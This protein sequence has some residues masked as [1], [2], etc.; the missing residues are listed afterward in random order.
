MSR[1]IVGENQKNNFPVGKTSTLPPG[2]LQGVL[3]PFL[4]YHRARANKRKTVFAF[5]ASLRNLRESLLTE[6]TLHRCISE[7]R[8]YSL[9]ILKKKKTEMIRLRSIITSWPAWAIVMFA[10]M[11][12][13]EYLCNF[14]TVQYFKILLMS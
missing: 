12:L 5:E 10:I 4:K 14:N 9:R 3:G 1:S 13:L 7:T 8:I 2:S 11:A 6:F